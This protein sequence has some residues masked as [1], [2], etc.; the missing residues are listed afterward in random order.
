[1]KKE[2]LL[3]SGEEDEAPT[4]LELLEHTA[5][6]GITVHARNLRELFERAAWGM[7]WCI[8]DMGPVRP[9]AECEVSVTAPDREALLIRWLAEL[10]RL[11]HTD[12]MLFCR[13]RIVRLDEEGLQAQV[14]GEAIEPERHALY[15][16]IKGVTFHGLS[17][18]QEET[19]WRATVLF[20]V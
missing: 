20:D 4:W 18:D 8:T 6:E 7:F 3:M 9:A 2:A 15:A 14:A 12:A 11:H 10:N 19:G 5:D 16:E 1:M 13:F 17:I